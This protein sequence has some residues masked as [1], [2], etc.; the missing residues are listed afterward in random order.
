MNINRQF[1]DQHV[2]GDKGVD[3]SAIQK[4][5]R[6]I[7]LLYHQL[8]DYSYVMGDLYYST[9]YDSP[10]WD[11]LNVLEAEAERQEFIRH[12]GLVMIYA[13]ASEVLDGSGAYLT[14]DRHRYKAIATAVNALPEFDT[15]TNR[16]I[17]AVRGALKLINEKRGSWEES[18]EVTN[19]VSE[20]SWIHERYVRQYFID[21]A[22]AFE[23]DSFYHP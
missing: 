19:V 6:D 11:Y 5:E 14:M 17:Q 3:W 23:Q 4:I 8:A 20:S 7:C 12:G 18:P 21:R 2:P 13:M 1:Q 10:Y 22:R 16:L 15:D 9:V